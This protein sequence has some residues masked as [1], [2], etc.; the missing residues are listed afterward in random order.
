MGT[1]CISAWQGKNICHGF[2]LQADV[3]MIP[4][5]PL[6]P[7]RFDQVGLVTCT[8]RPKWCVGQLT[9]DQMTWNFFAKVHLSSDRFSQFRF[10]CCAIAAG[11]VVVVVVVVAAGCQNC[12]KS[13][14]LYGLAPLARIRIGPGACTIRQIGSVFNVGKSKPACCWGVG[15]AQR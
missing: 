5:S 2:P 13:G 10:H 14:R 9:F 4:P 3:F 12:R 6:R 11:V 1:H 7:Y 15:I 8:C